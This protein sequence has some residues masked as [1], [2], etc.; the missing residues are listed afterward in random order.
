MLSQIPVSDHLDTMELLQRSYPELLDDIDVH[1]LVWD[2]QGVL[3]W[4]KDPLLCRMQELGLIDLNIT[5][6]YGQ[7]GKLSNLELRQLAKRMG[8][9][10]S[11]YF[12]LS[13]VQEW[14]N[15]FSGAE[16]Q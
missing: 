7:M 3:R 13:Y 1:P 8:Y 6:A 12:D 10:L 14:A 11:G 9:S 16:N 15:G 5:T 4:K 2:E